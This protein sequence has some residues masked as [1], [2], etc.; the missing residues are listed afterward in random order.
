VKARGRIACVL[1]ACG[2]LGACGGNPAPHAAG[3]APAPLDPAIAPVPRER[4]ASG[5]RDVAVP[6][7]MYHLVASAPVGS[8]YPGLWVAPGRFASEVAALARAGYRATTLD[9]VWRAWHGR[10]GLPA[11]PLV[12]SFDDGY[13]S[14]FT[15]ARPLLDALD[16]PAVLN[17]EVKN[18]G[19]AGGLSRIEVGDLVRDGWEVDA[20]TLTHPDLTSVGALTLRREVA[21]SRRWLRQV[22]GIP[23][24]FF[25]Y[26][27]GRYDARV[28]AAVRVAGYRGAVTTAPGLASP[29]G[30]PDTLPRIRVTPAMTAATLLARLRSRG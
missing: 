17:L 26:P 24:D 21:G 15:R 18:V 5:P 29:H 13:E 23:V 20:H 8:R 6:I 19:L 27:A 28:E 10:G 14:Q 25:A 1:V 11:R 7:L 16:W 12:I 30:D 4:A 9:A 3:P 22:F 2:A